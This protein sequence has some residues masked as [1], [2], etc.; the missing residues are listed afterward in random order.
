MTKEP[1][2]AVELDDLAKAEED[3]IWDRPTLSPTL[4]IEEMAQRQEEMAH[5]KEV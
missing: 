3:P 4:I 5:R 1:K 2:Q